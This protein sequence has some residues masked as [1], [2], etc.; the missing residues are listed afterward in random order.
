MAVKFLNLRVSRPSPPGKFLVQISVRGGVDPRSIVWLEWLG[1]MKNPE[2]SSGIE[3]VSSRFVA[4]CLNQLRYRMPHI[5]I[6][7]YVLTL[8]SNSKLEYFNILEIKF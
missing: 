3:P 5:Y 6:Y 8:N 4:L 1:Q 7:I 2:T